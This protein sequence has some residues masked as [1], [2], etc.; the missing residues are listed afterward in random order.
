MKENLNTFSARA[1]KFVESPEYFQ[2]GI[3]SGF[4]V[5]M[6]KHDRILTVFHGT[7][8]SELEL[9][10]AE[11]LS[12]FAVNKKIPEIWSIHFREI[13]SFL[14]DENHLP[15]FQGEQKNLEEV[16]RKLKMLLIVSASMSALSS[17]CGRYS[18]LLLNWETLSLADRNAFLGE[19]IRPMGFELVLYF[20]DVLTVHSLGPHGENSDLES[21]VLG[22]LG[23]MGKVLPMKVVAV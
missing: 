20:E 12:K 7:F 8:Q 15:A 9:I 11:V 22:I 6:D 13:E 17:N 5:T 21:V 1:K 4:L 3:S 19:I 18:Q 23:A 16:L 2:V 10:F 14:R